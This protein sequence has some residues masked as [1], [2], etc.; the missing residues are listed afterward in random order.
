MRSERLAA[1]NGRAVAEGTAD[2]RASLPTSEEATDRRASLP[3]ADRRATPPTADRRASLP[4]ADRRSSPPTADRRSFL[5]AAGLTAAVGLAGCLGASAP[6]AGP[7]AVAERRGPADETASATF[8]G[9]L[10]N[11]GYHPEVTVPDA[12]EVDWKIP[13]INVG[14]HTAAKAS[15]VLDP[16]GNYVIPGDTGV[17]TSVTPDG[18]IRWTASTEPSRNGIH[19]TAT[20]ANGL[21]YVGAYDGAL[22]AFDVDTGRRVWRTKLGDSIGSS[23]VYHDGTVYVAVEFATPSGA[24]FGVDALSGRITWRD[25]RP[26]DHSHA[27]I[28]I[29][30]DAGRLI[31]GANDGFLYG[32]SYPDLERVWAFETGGPIKGPIA[33]YDGGAFFGSWDHSIY[34]V[35]LEDGRERWSHETTRKVMGGAAIDP[36]SGVLYVGGHDAKLHALE[37]ASGEQRWA[38]DTGGWIIGSASTTGEHVLTGSND[39]NLYAIRTDTG[40]R[41][42]AAFGGG[43][44]VSSDPLLTDVGI[45][46]TVR[47]TAE[48][49]GDAVK[50]VAA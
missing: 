32:W 48:E 20:V 36:E 11:R 3:T 10:E 38:F 33:T 12:V 9:G 8:R 47:A 27:T 2:R 49:S 42:W 29:D 25:A 17:V 18:R 43:G 22:Y 1:G 6:R 40:E 13:G 41:E 44:D 16:A 15:A 5:R 45:V 19:G 23:P 21:V 37:A 46:F 39:G 26:T 30:L 4:T 50:L 31:V 7:S 34:R 28:A 35:S 14:E 24:V